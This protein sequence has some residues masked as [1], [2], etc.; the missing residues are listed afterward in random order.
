MD[1]GYLT[2]YTATAIARGKL[3]PGDKTLP[4]GRLGDVKIQGDNVILGEPFT[5]N[6]ENIDQFDF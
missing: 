4:A 2:V 3:M 5:F 6:Q 1:L